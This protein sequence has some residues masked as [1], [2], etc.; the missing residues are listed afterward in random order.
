MRT[1]TVVTTLYEYD[2]ILDSQNIYS[3]RDVNPYK[4]LLFL[5]H[6]PT[7]VLESLQKLKS[8]GSPYRHEKLL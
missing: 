8:E 7:V 1:N 5:C 3:Q 2:A 4:V 6:D